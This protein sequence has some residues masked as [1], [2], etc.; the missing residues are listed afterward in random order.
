LLPQLEP[1]PG[2]PE[3]IFTIYALYPDGTVKAVGATV[4]GATVVGARVVGAAVGAAV[5]YFA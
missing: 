3:G 2:V 4:V 1:V 5:V